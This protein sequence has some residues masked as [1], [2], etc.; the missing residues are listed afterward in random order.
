VLFSTLEHL[1]E[2]AE[3]YGETF[4]VIIFDIDNFKLLND[5]YGHLAG[6]RVLREI[7]KEV[8]KII[9]RSDIFGRYGGEEFLIILPKT[10]DPY[11]VAEK[12]RKCRVHRF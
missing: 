3:R 11:P 6:D 4:S 1:I 12:I 8:K 10:K 7:A 5:T 9:R 2:Y